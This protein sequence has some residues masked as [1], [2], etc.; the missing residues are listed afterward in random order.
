MLG[1][2][3][4]GIIQE[5]IQAELK[6][7]SC[8]ELRYESYNN[9]QITARSLLPIVQILLQAARTKNH[10]DSVEIPIIGASELVG[11][12][13]R[14]LVEPTVRTATMPCVSSPRNHRVLPGHLPLMV[15]LL[16]YCR[17]CVAGELLKFFISPSACN[18][19]V[20]IGLRP[21][22]NGLCLINDN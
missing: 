5:I 9:G 1:I 4:T 19:D 2:I 11:K 15:N 22:K 8:S 6:K 17:Y 20:P 14:K 21:V 12:S 16:R 7:P 10:A 3:R 18:D 13:S